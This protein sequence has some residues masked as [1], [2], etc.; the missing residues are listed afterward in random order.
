MITTEMR[1]TTAILR[2]DRSKKNPIDLELLVEMGEALNSFRDDPEVHGLVIG[3]ASERFFSIGFDIPHLYGLSREDF[4]VFYRAFTEFCLA[5]YTFPKPTAAAV[6]GHAT[7][8]GFIL[9]LACDYRILAQGHLLMGL[10]EAKLGVPVPFFSALVLEKI[11][12]KVHAGNIIDDG[13]FFLPEDALEMRIADYV[14]PADEVLPAAMETVR[15][16]DADILGAF[17]DIKRARTDRIDKTV[18]AALDE[19]TRIFIE[20]WYAPEVREN[21]KEAMKKY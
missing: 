11:A 1:D 7:A 2:L 16:V 18:R 5:L 20:R 10:N 12:G 21:L 4:G 15:G 14:L 9:T 8:G 19:K 17:G 6:L 13:E 3:S